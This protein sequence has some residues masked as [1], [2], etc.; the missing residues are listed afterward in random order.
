MTSE[1]CL[2]WVSFLPSAEDFS[3]I[4]YEPCS[5]ASTS[6]IP[7]NGLPIIKKP[8]V[9][10]KRRAPKRSPSGSTLVEVLPRVSEEDERASRTSITEDENAAPSVLVTE[11]EPTSSSWSSDDEEPTVVPSTSFGGA[12]LK[13][14]RKHRPRPLGFIATRQHVDQEF[15]ISPAMLIDESSDDEVL[16]SFP[17]P[18][19]STRTPTPTEPSPA[20]ASTPGFMTPL[21]TTPAFVSRGSQSPTPS[22]AST[23]SASSLPRTPGG[24]S[25]DEDECEKSTPIIRLASLNKPLPPRPRTLHSMNG[26]VDGEQEDM[27]ER[28]VN[29]IFELLASG[30]DD[31]ALADT[32]DNDDDD[33]PIQRFSTGPSVRG[34]S[35]SFPVSPTSSTTSPRRT[36]SRA[37]KR[38]IPPVPVSVSVESTSPLDPT[39]PTGSVSF[40]LPLTMALDIPRPRPSPPRTPLPTDIPVDV[41][42]SIA[43]IVSAGSYSDTSV[44]DAYL[45]LESADLRSRFSIST[46]ASRS[47]GSRPRRAAAETVA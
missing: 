2:D 33:A 8:A 1:G 47:R 44:L 28:R 46:R 35:S 11:E 37:P 17:P 39:S 43:T 15:V 31:A 13:R 38:P 36:Y 18:P 40:A 42:A 9:L 16:I 25:E 4:D 24:S 29:E 26:L 21:L 12:I 32:S 14:I 3:S 23:T 41:R 45:A 6:A 5:V 30:G 7:D 10:K 27:W 22:F 19:R 20:C 34:A